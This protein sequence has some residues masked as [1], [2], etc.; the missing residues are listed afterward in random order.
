ME[1]SVEP[2][3]PWWHQK[4]SRLLSAGDARGALHAYSTALAL[5]PFRFG[6]W[7]GKGQALELL[8]RGDEALD[9][10]DIAVSLGPHS[11]AAHEA[12]G[13]LLHKRGAYEQA[14]ACF[15][16]ATI[17][18]ATSA[19]RMAWSL[20]YRAAT[21]IKLGRL[22]E[23]IAAC[24]A[25]LELHPLDV[26]WLTRG[27]ALR[28]LRRFDEAIVSHN[29]A[30]ALNPTCAE[31]RFNRALVEEDQGRTHAAILS[32]QQCLAVGTC[33]RALEQRVRRR[34]TDAARTGRH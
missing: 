1:L 12:K 5:D 29:Q 25:G 15:E 14:L 4:A 27:N 16:H 11:F 9:H 10:Y 6:T 32:Y 20:N 13:L 21:L 30:L 17:V 3:A 34:L 22:K 28:N 8:G 26:L 33:D 24:E 23:A 7:L 2:S 19:P 31:A 18:G